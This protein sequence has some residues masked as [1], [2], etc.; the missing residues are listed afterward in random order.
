MLGLVADG[1]LVRNQVIWAKTNPMP[2][3]VANRLSY[4]HEILYFLVRSPRY[5]FDL[6]AIRAPFR[7]TANVRRTATPVYPPPE[8]VPP[9]ADPNGG[10]HRLKTAGLNGHPLGKNPGDVWP[11]PTASLRGEHF[12]TFPPKLIEPCVLAG[13]KP[14][15]FVLDPFFGSGTVGVVSN[16]L[17]SKYVGIELNPE[18]ISIAS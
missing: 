2:C 11:L 14:G 12:A 1:W 3:S 4:T 10:L 13:T 8:A 9:D 17:G 5:F 15:D 7:T 16:E 18:Y 6:D